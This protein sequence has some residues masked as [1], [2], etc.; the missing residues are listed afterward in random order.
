MSMILSKSEMKSSFLSKWT[1]DYVPAI[2]EYAM[3]SRKKTIRSLMKGMV[4]DE[5]G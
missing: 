1:N 3:G 5:E 4:Y 2:L